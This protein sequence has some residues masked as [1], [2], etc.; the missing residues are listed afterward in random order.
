MLLTVAYLVASSLV[1]HSH[2]TGFDNDEDHNL[3]NS[4]KTQ[5]LIASVNTAG[6]LNTGLVMFLN[7]PKPTA[8]EFESPP[9]SAFLVLIEDI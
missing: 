6:D 8:L 4:T 5:I 3:P 9:N 7:A 2:Q 1:L